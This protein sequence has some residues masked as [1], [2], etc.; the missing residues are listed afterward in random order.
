MSTSAFAPLETDVPVFDVIVSLATGATSESVEQLAR[1]HG[2]LSSAQ[3]DGFVRALRNNPRVK[4]GDHIPQERVDVAR[5]QFTKLGLTVNVVPV[6]SLQTKTD[7]DADGRFLCRACNNRVELPAT[8]QCP[9]CGVFVDKITDEFLL[10]KKIME[11]ERAKLDYANKKNEAENSK[12][13]TRSMEEAIRRQIREELEAEMGIA[14]KTGLFSGGA[15]LARLAGV[16]LL[17]VAAFFGGRFLPAGKWSNML[18]GKAGVAANDGARA[19]VDKM[20]NT[21]SPAGSSDPQVAAGQ[22]GDGDLDDPMIQSLTGGKKMGGKGLTIEQAIAASKTL[23]GVVGNT[24]ADRAMNGTAAGTATGANAAEG[25]VSPVTKQILTADFAKQLAELGQ[26]R[27]AREVIKVARPLAAEAPAKAALRQADLE[28]R[29]WATRGQSAGSARQTMDDLMVDL[30]TFTDTVE[31]SVLAARLGVILSQNDRLPPEAAR[32]FLTFAA[33]ALKTVGDGAQRARA[34]TEWQVAM[35]QV[36]QYEVAAHARAGRTAKAQSMFEQLD[37]LTKGVN[38]LGALAL[39]NASAHKASTYLGQS[40]KATDSL[41]LAIALAGKI[42]APV[43]RA[44][45]LRQVAQSIGS[46]SPRSL[47]AAVASLRN[48]IT[49]APSPANA[50]ALVQLALLY[51]D[52]GLMEKSEEIATEARSV[53]GL[54][55][56]AAQQVQSD[57]LVRGGMAE[58]KLLH[59]DAQYAAAE[60]TMERVGG[61]LF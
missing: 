59:R 6:L 26:W 12:F 18:G 20:L 56:A 54:A 45:V 60:A 23:A 16:L 4:I 30:G 32:A 2:D 7:L 13:N 31:R 34:M 47:Q 38:D 9:K 28:S 33:D 55:G 17:V 50:T 15:G 52:F 44:T 14:K 29:A 53:K 36:I 40:A 21:V 39:L 61:Y 19:D 37:P 3:I 42:A 27:R 35:G 22:S 25:S 41:E 1:Q 57:L 46:A 5:E 49:A 43:E 10:R 24:T 8:R 11:Q 51:A 48:Q 58:A